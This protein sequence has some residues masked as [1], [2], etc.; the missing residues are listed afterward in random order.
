MV[1]SAVIQGVVSRV[2]SFFPAGKAWGQGIQRS[3]YWEI[4]D[5]TCWNGVCSWVVCEAANDRCFAAPSQEGD[6]AWLRTWRPQIC[7]RNTGDSHSKK[8]KRS[9]GFESLCLSCS[10]VQRFERASKY[11]MCAQEQRKYMC[12]KPR[13][14]RGFASSA[15]RPTGFNGMER[16]DFNMLLEGRFNIFFL[17]LPIHSHLHRSFCIYVS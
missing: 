14:G 4:R 1:G 11:A 3:H 15:N 16:D 12:G 10:D 9:N 2:S 8:T 6:Q 13:W 7:L 17:F 5:G